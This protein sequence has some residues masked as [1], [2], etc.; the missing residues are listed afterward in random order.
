[1][2][3]TYTSGSGYYDRSLLEDGKEIRLRPV[4]PKE[5]SQVDPESMV[6]RAGGPTM[7]LG[8]FLG[9][10]PGAYESALSNNRQSGSAGYNPS[11]AGVFRTWSGGRE[12]FR[13]PARDTQAR[14]GLHIPWEDL[15]PNDFT[16][17]KKDNPFPCDGIGPCSHPEAYPSSD[18]RTQEEIE[19]DLWHPLNTTRFILF[20]FILLAWYYLK[21]I[22]MGSTFGTELH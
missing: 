21:Q 19:R 15:F 10:D 6:P 11:T 7:T 17:S 14:S 9:V 22:P 4:A 2:R 16:E 5:D 18:N 13:S 3:R 20:Q 12:N 8:D 1:M